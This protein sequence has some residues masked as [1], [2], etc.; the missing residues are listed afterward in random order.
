MVRGIFGEPLRVSVDYLV[1]EQSGRQ[2]WSKER[3]TFE[4]N[5][6]RI[7]HPLLNSAWP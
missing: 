4:W 1:F 5:S 7:G 2:E 3:I 6:P